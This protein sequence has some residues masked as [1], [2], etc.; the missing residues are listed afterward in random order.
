MG[1]IRNGKKVYNGA[2]KKLYNWAVIFVP[3]CISNCSHRKIQKC[4]LSNEHKDISNKR[5]KL[6]TYFLS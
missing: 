5:G 2:G 3:T 1:R 6:R 4:G